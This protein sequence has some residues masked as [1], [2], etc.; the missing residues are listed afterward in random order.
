MSRRSAGLLMFRRAPG[1]SGAARAGSR[2]LEVFLVHPGGPFA[3]HRDE[4]AWSLPKGEF[5]P[6]GNESSLDVARREFGEETGR[7][8][9]A[10]RRAGD[11][12]DAKEFIPLGAVAQRGGKRVEAWAFE[13]D[14]PEGQPVVSNT[15]AIEWPPRSGKQQEF[16]EVDDGAFFPL[17]DARRRILDAQAVFLDRLVAHLERGAGA[18]GGG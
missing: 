16:P 4:P 10:C 14:W 2:G 8:V 11:T 15:F 13:G 9:E 12:G 17:A 5:D 3:K 18:A 1:A 7:A 6:A